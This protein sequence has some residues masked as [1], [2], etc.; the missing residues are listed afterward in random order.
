MTLVL[1][2]IDDTLIDHSSAVAAGVSSLYAAIHPVVSQPAFLATWH[3]AMRQQFPRYLSGELTYQD[4]R[5]A[6]LRQTVSLELT[7]AQADELFDDYAR[8]YE[9]HWALFSDVVSCLDG[10]TEHRLGIISN[11]YGFEQRR[12]LERTG[13]AERFETIHISSECGQPKPAAE[14]F[15]RACRDAGVAWRDAVY[16]GDAYETDALGARRAGLHGVWLDRTQSRRADHESPVI[17]GLGELADLLR[18]TA[19]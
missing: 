18:A 8:A 16:I 19:V 2:D 11:G 12:K 14:I 10:L 7:D 15:H 4:Q 13:I 17:C 5:R 9:A 3:E 6:R 1:F